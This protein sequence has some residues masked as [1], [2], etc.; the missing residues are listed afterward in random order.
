L[1]Y[2]AIE[3]TNWLAEHAIRFGVI[4]RKVWGGNRTW[5]GARAQSVPMSVCRTCWQQGRSALDFLSLLLRGTP[6]GQALPPS[7]TPHKSI[8]ATTGSFSALPL[9]GRGRRYE[10]NDTACRH[11]QRDSAI[12]YPGPAGSALG[13]AV[14]RKQDRPLNHAFADGVSNYRGPRSETTCP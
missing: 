3:A 13:C 4:L 7:P 8:R 14:T 1:N 11:G 9:L 6:A 5:A 12:I 10:D 2:P